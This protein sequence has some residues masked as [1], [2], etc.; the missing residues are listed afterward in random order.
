M[1][2]SLLLLPQTMSYSLLGPWDVLHSLGA[3]GGAA[4]EW[5][6]EKVAQDSAPVN[7]AFGIPLSP[8]ATIEDVE[9]TDLVIVPSL[10]LDLENW[11]A[12]QEPV[13]HW[14]R[15]QATM[16]ATVA[17]VCTGAFLLAEAGLL[18]GRRAT[19]HWAFADQFRQRYPHVLLDCDE[20]LASDGRLCTAGA[21]LAWQD[22]LLAVL[23][24][25]LEESQLLQL[26]QLFLMQA[27]EQGQKPHRGLG[28]MQHADA[29][30]LDAQEWLGRHFASEDCVE[31]AWR[32]SALHQRT[33]QRRFRKAAG[34]TPSHYVQQLRMEAAKLV[35]TMGNTA[36]EQVGHDVGYGDSSF[37]RRLFRK[38]TGMTP[39]AF[40]QRFRT[41]SR[42][43]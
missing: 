7:C 16:G 40:R 31:Q 8:D 12:G 41:G 17:S 20:V 1:K 19:T 28:L 32:R 11:F 21:G 18:D 4:R 25:A 26:R 23:D 6:I 9:Q 35:L 39:S 37:F 10:S 33:F 43:D 27:H 5:R 42:T 38:H 3:V 24:G 13:L 15:R 14:L 29:V 36:I 22:L 2:I 30:V 34:V